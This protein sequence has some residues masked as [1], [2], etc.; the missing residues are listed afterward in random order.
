MRRML[1]PLDEVLAAVGWRAATSA[2][3]GEGSDVSAAPTPEPE[4]AAPVFCPV[5]SPPSSCARSAS[6]FGDAVVAGALEDDW[7]VGD[8][9]ADGAVAIGAGEEDGCAFDPL[10]VQGGPYGEVTGAAGVTGATD[11]SARN[12]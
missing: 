2:A 10:A 3:V 6:V 4:F 1:G 7:S 12:D 9:A 11:G 5:E 8:C